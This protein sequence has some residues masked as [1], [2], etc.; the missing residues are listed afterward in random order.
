M[1][2]T[3]KETRILLAQDDEDIYLEAA[4]KDLRARGIPDE[5]PTLAK[6]IINVLNGAGSIER[7]AF[8]ADPT[9]F[10]T[11]AGIYRPKVRLIPDTILKRIAIQ[12]SLVSN[13][14]RA[15]QNHIASFGRPRP[16]RFSLGYVIKPN[17]GL[18]DKLDEGG[19]KDLQKEIEKA[20]NLFSTC[21]HTSGMDEENKSTFSEYLSLSTRSAI[22]CGRVATE[23]VWAADPD[24]FEKRTFHHFV[25]TDSGTIYPTTNDK[26]A[27]QSVRNEA[28]NLLCQVTGQKLIKEKYDKQEYA[29]V[30]VI[31]T[32]P[33]MVFTRE[34]MLVYN[35][36]AV[37]DVELGGFPVTPLDTVIS[38]VTT[39]INI[40]TL[41]K[42]WFQ[43]GRASKGFLV[44]KSEDA[45]PQTL[46]A[47][48]Q[49]FN[50]SINNVNSAYRTPLFSCGVDEQITW[51]PMDVGAGRDMEYQYLADQNAREI[52]TAFLMSPDE[53]P[54]WSYLSRGTN[55]QALSEGNNEFKI[56]A[57]RDVG[58]R[59]LLSGFEDFIN[60]HLFPL[61]APN[62]VG[63]CRFQFV[64][65]ESDNAEKEAVRTQQDMQI[66]MTMDDVLERVEKKP[67]TREWGGTI[68][69]N[70]V[71]KS[72]LDQYYTVGQ[73]LEHFCGIKDASKDPML[74][75]RRDPMFF[76]WYQLQQ[77]QEMVKQQ[78]Q[79]QGRQ[80]QGQPGG[81]PG[82]PGQQEQP[83]QDA[84]G[85]SAPGQKTQNDQSSQVAQGTDLARSV[86]QAYGLLQK[87]EAQLPPDKRR[88][89][90]QQ[91]KTV[92]FFV[93][94]FMGDT[95]EAIEAILDLPELGAPKPKSKT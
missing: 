79:Q 6:S 35:F 27:A 59:P 58:I 60:T 70:Q 71:Y 31:D 15:R 47:I 77:Q 66:W 50:S 4:K 5:K 33:I 61:I 22:V 11:Y 42:L 75:Y 68:P 91:E 55:S 81:Q 74:A 86:D 63:K 21:G 25:A 40:T 65:L 44:I 53:L 30:Q 10:N 93:K 32:R 7:L 88:L 14:V 89:I 49:N 73:I 64:G 17:V 2:E 36:Y 46:H 3:K 72:Y 43:N 52:L 13:I 87:N 41:N 83:S 9:A 82:Q 57:A 85:S 1:A 94:G 45:T 18:L 28:Y 8:E 90:S 34:E 67:M 20:I 24:N 48:K 84:G 19:K 76:Q 29:W 69:L 16:D 56:E 62:L 12:D 23:I 95:E 92:D 39:H 37:P 38:A 51:Q 80:P 78:A 54:G 26:K